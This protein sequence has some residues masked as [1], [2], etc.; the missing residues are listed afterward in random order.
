ML[1]MKY[2]SFTVV[3]I[4]ILSSCDNF[5]GNQESTESMLD[6]V[7]EYQLADS[8]SLLTAISSRLQDLSID[9]FFEQSYRVLRERDIESLITD[10]QF[11][12]INTETANL[13]NISDEHYLQTIQ[14]KTLILSGLQEYDRDSLS[15]KNQLSYDIYESY[16]EFELEWSEYRDF[17]YPASYSFFGWPGSTEFFFTQSFTLSNKDQAELYLVLLNQTGRRFDQIIELLDA[18]KQGGIIEPFRTLNLSLYQV[19]SI[20]RNKATST[21][22]YQA[23]STQIAA[24]SNISEIDKQALKSQ[25]ELIIEHRVLPAYHKLSKKM[26]S[27]LSDAPV[28]I[29]FGQFEGGKKFYDFCL[30]FYTSG[31]LSSDQIHHLGLQELNRIHNQMRV[32][33]DQL[34]Y[35]QNES[36]TQLY[37]RVDKDGGTISGSNSK[38][39]YEDLITQTYTE[40]SDIFDE[41]PDQKIVVI[42]GNSGGYYVAGSDDGLRPGAFYAN[43]STSLAYTRMP[44]LAYHEAIPG[45]HLQIALANE[46]DLPLFRRKIIF[47]SYSEGWAL[48]AER[49]AYDLGWYSGDIY[50]DLGRLQF[51]A[52]RAARLV[53]DTGI[54]NRGWTYFQANQFHQDNVGMPGSITRYSVWPGQATAYMTGM[55]KILE[56]RQMA[57]DQLGSLY[58]IKDFHSEI[59]GNG[60]MPVDILHSVVDK[61]ITRQ[62]TGTQ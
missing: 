42:G 38:A 28:N 49:L 37:N 44:T 25:L 58:D 59:I 24:L 61:Y 12:N 34:G 36:I 7:P 18:R 31:D 9:E 45:H 3:I 2:F 1:M 26:Q 23:F 51:E 52:M 53:I 55:L 60:S 50:G 13:N 8:A 32:L 22:Y 39:F 56:L 62:L 20:S 16:L 48:Y 15:A 11:E 33:F 47:T 14:I 4:L 5:D 43:T 30:R 29:G 10:R 40:L 21:R 57:Q 46:M 35:P 54:H 19:S 27:L 17:E 41:L 6:T